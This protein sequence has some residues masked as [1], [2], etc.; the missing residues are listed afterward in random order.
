MNGE[1][2]QEERQRC[3][4]RATIKARGRSHAG[5]IHDVSSQGLRL[6][7]DEVADIWAGD[8]LELEIEGFGQI[9]GV[10]RWR[11]PGKAG[12]QLHEM[13]YDRDD[14]EARAA[15]LASLLGNG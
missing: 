4:V 7:T 9:N 3:R 2:R 14:R 8:E 6:S 5:W 1:Q 15:A 10:A 13:L 12:V 11:V